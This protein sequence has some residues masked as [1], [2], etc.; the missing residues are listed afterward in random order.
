MIL[1]LNDE[2]FELSREN[3]IP[4]NIH[5]KK[6]LVKAGNSKIL[7]LFNPIWLIN[8][9]IPRVT[10]PAHFA[11]QQWLK[12]GP[13]MYRISNSISSNIPNEYLLYK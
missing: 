1:S 10:V 9:K 3:L 2:F 12:S 4:S 6:R 8:S 5:K 7:E 11:L 13:I